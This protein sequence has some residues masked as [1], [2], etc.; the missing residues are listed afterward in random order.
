MKKIFAAFLVVAFSF[1]ANV[2]ALSS[3]SASSWQNLE[4]R[5]GYDSSQR[6][7]I[8]EFSLPTSFTASERYILTMYLDGQ[9]YRKYFKYDSTHKEQVVLFEVDAYNPKAFYDMGIKIEDYQFNEIFYGKG[10]INLETGKVDL[11]PSS[12]PYTGSNTPIKSSTNT[13]YSSY[14]GSYSSYAYTDP[15]WMWGIS[16][17]P[18]EV[19]YVSSNYYSNGVKG[20]TNSNSNTVYVPNSNSTSTSGS[21]SSTRNTS[22]SRYVSVDSYLKAKGYGK[23]ATQSQEPKTINGIWNA[24]AY[25]SWRAS[26]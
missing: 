24:N 6:E 26:Y 3:I 11:T 17:N 10:G 18:L 23:Y 12:N 25:S 4:V 19:Q 5:G 15:N 9:V 20:T 13:R 14:F 8:V 2:F 21:N 22:S 7:L 16:R 1:Q